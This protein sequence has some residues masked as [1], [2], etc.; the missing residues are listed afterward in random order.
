MATQILS[1]RGTNDA[2]EKSLGELFADLARDTSTLVR[3]EFSLA[4]AEV[5]KKAKDA[6]GHVAKIA[7]GGVLAFAG[8]LVLLSAVVLILT[9]VAGM[10]AWGAA[11]LVALLTLGVG[12]F[13]AKAGMGALKEADLAPRQTIETLKEDAEWTKQQVG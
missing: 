12:A 3:Q 8:F 11:L 13:L 4:K 10:P 6:G 9:Q 2:H 7:V 5:G 1:D